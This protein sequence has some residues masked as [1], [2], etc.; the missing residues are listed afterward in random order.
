MKKRI[1][2][3]VLTASLLV[4]VSGCGTSVIGKEESS[5]VSIEKDKAKKMELELNVGAGELSVNNGADN[6]VEG[7]IEYNDARLKPEV[8]YQLKGNKGIGVIEQQKKKLDKNIAKVKNKW[9][10]NLNNKIPTDLSVNSGATETK[11]D[12]EGLNLS[13]LEVNAGVGNITLDLGG[14]WKKGFDASMEMGVG[15]ST[16]ILPTDVGVKIKSFKGM[17]KAEFVGLI[18]R[19]NGVYVNEAYEDADVIINIKTELGIGETIFKL[20]K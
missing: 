15:K 8:S 13:G 4:L 5:R 2:L 12:L 11:L 14:K 7:T 9:E 1:F 17:G 6:W 19:G 3:G 20:E 10:L 16:I 18:S